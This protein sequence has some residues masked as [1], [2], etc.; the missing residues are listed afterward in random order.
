MPAPATALVG[1][2]WG[3]G[4]LGHVA[5][6]TPGSF[7]AFVSLSGVEVP[8]S[9]LRSSLPK[10]VTWGGEGGLEVLGAQI[11]QWEQLGSPAHVAEFLGAGHWDYLSRG[12]TVCDQSPGRGDCTLT[13]FLSADIVACFLTRYL[14]P[15]GVPHVK[16]GPFEPFEVVRSLRRP[17][18]YPHYLTTEQQFYAGGHLLAWQAV[19]SRPECGVVLRWVIGQGV[20]EM[21]HG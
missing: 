7:S 14:R 18:I 2:S 10:L 9:V 12:A 3:A 16:V 15:E 11:S 17:V 8:G 13:P 1:H 21:T 6:A 5:A 20:G 19:T 4:L